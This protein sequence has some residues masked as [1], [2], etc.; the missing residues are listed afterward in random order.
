M[1][2]VKTGEWAGHAIRKAR[3]QYKCD[4]WTEYDRACDKPI[5]KGDYYTEGH[6]NDAA[7]VSDDR[8]PFQYYRH[9]MECAGQ[10]ARQ[11]L[12]DAL[13]DKPTIKEQVV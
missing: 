8:Y 12:A 3:N 6:L 4:C 13:Q 7:R 1:I 10:D 9:C 2:T 5:N 11:S